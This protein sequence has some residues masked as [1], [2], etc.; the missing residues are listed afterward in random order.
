MNKMLGML[1]RVDTLWCWFRLSLGDIDTSVLIACQSISLAA[2][3]HPSSSW[4]L[5]RTL[6][7]TVAYCADNSCL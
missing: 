6:E 2:S 7:S 1:L 4:S 3:I 5:C